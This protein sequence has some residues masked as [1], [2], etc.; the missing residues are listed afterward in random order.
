[1]NGA[2]RVQVGWHGS[3]N[4]D[5]FCN[6]CKCTTRK[7]GK[8]GARLQCQQKSCAVYTAGKVCKATTCKFMYSFNSKREIMQVT[9]NN[10]GDVW[11]KEESMG[12]HHRCAYHYKGATKSGPT[13]AGYTHKGTKSTAHHT[14]KYGHGSKKEN[15]C[16]CMCYAPSTSIFQKDVHRVSMDMD[17]TTDQ[18]KYGNADQKENYN[19]KKGAALNAKRLQ[20]NKATHSNSEYWVNKWG[21]HTATQNVD[22]KTRKP[23]RFPTKSPTEF[24]TTTPAPT[25]APTFNPTAYP[26]STPTSIP[27]FGDEDESTNPTAIWMAQSWKNIVTWSK[28]VDAECITA[29]KK[30]RNQWKTNTMPFTKH[31]GDIVQQMTWIGNMPLYAA[32]KYGFENTDAE[33]WTVKAQGQFINDWWKNL[34]AYNL[35]AYKCAAYDVASVDTNNG[36][37]DITKMPAQCA[38]VAAKTTALETEVRAATDTAKWNGGEL[39][40]ACVDGVQRINNKQVS[41]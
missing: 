32:M 38:D 41:C 8:T 23:T 22:G 31:G 33:R 7:G 19:F 3:G 9:H 39:N 16:L 36:V 13:K 6:L 1:M 10:M 2:Q 15:H 11:N 35:S 21:D 40:T 25:N 26:T 34:K 29:I 30:E 12:S 17:H 18:T 5:N 27:T 14:T 24:D 37:S 4:G 20:D 28:L